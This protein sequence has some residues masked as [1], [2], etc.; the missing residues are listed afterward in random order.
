MVFSHIE[1]P[2]EASRN[3]RH[4]PA[5]PWYLYFQSWS[6]T[7]ITVRLLKHWCNGNLV[8][9]TWLNVSKNQERHLSPSQCT[10]IS[11][12][13]LSCGWVLR[14]YK[15]RSTIRLCN[16]KWINW[17]DVCTARCIS[18]KFAGISHSLLT[19][20]LRYSNFSISPPMPEECWMQV[21]VMNL[22]CV[23]IKHPNT[24]GCYIYMA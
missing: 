7:K 9:W 1:F 14:K 24:R 15:P 12:Q 17:I 10:K 22:G 11:R 16:R 21:R 5:L 18:S 6:N 3:W 8:R 20:L 23:V 2:T 4:H 13:A 19:N